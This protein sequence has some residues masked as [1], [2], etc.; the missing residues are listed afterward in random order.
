MTVTAAA[1][2]TFS[3]GRHSRSDRTGPRTK[4]DV[5]TYRH[6]DSDATTVN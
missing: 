2:T 1:S 3:S 5:R 4:R 6:T